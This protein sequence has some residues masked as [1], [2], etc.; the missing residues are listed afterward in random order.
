MWMAGSSR[1]MRRGE[2]KK[3]ARSEE[4]GDG[5]WEREIKTR[6]S[7][8]RVQIGEGDTPQL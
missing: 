4:R 1:G 5:R 3:L 7:M 6:L 8:G 2:T